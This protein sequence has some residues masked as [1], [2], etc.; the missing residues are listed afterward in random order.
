MDRRLFNHST[1]SSHPKHTRG[2]PT[3]GLLNMLGNIQ[4]RRVYLERLDA[5]ER[6]EMHDS[7]RGSR[8]CENHFSTY[9]GRGKAGK[10]PSTVL[11]PRLLQYD[12]VDMIKGQD[13]EE[14]GFSARQSKRKRKDS[15]VRTADWND[16]TFET[17]PQVRVRRFGDLVTR[18]RG[19]T[20]RHTSKRDLNASKG[21]VR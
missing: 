2:V 13:E 21:G 16:G 20:K 19:Y 3:K 9:A 12:V 18:A 14:R 6:D 17:D 5:S 11:W 4:G 7:S 8:F 10:D 1:S 15:D